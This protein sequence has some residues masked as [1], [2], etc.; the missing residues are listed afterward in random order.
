MEEVGEEGQIARRCCEYAAPARGG[1][2]DI[3][4]PRAAR[5]FDVLKPASIFRA[6]LQLGSSGT[7]IQ[8]VLR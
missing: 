7:G 3:S 4:P 2:Y 5:A 1:R 8:E 6:I